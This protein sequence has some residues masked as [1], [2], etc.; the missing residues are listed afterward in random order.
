[1]TSPRLV[2]AIQEF[3]TTILNPYDL[4]ELLHRV[5]G[6]ATALAHAQGAGIMLTDG[7]GKLE[8]AAASHQHVTELELLQGRIQV[9]AC[10]EAFS[11]GQVVLV[12]DLRTGYAHRWPE[13]TEQA[14][15]FGYHAVVSI[16]MIACGQTIGVLN[17]YRTSVGLWGPDEVV[18][19]KILTAMGAGYIL[20]ASELRAQHA[21]TDQLNEALQ[22]RD[23]IGQ[24]KGILM[25]RHEV[26]ADE[27]FDMLRSLSQTTHLKL[28]DVARKV[29]ASSQ[30]TEDIR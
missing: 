4:Q 18:A 22:N 6:H 11:T 13:Y 7:T 15:N 10:H 21:L 25:A 12:D 17:I 3:T 29:I 19:A 5:T 14:L 2:Q 8:F 23:A 28:R 1:M 26:G 30:T 24:A 16:P 9:G 27:A 20:H